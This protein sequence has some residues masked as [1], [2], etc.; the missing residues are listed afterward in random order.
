MTGP[1]TPGTDTPV[2]PRDGRADEPAAAT[3]M[4]ATTIE[5]NEHPARCGA[6][7]HRRPTSDPTP[8]VVGAEP[9]ARHPIRPVG[10][11]PSKGRQPGQVRTVLLGSLIAGTICSGTALLI[12]AVAVRVMF[13]RDGGTTATLLLWVGSI[14]GAVVGSWY[15]EPL[16]YHLSRTCR[17]SRADGR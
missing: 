11:G 3:E 2:T 1:D 7:G 4:P 9:A 8:T 12:A 14:G 13:G 15:S 6:R 10:V 17:E 5:V 16:V